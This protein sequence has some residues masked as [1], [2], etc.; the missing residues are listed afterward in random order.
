MSERSRN[1]KYQKMQERKR[2]LDKM[3]NA[4]AGGSRLDDADADAN[5]D[6]MFDEVTEE[7]YEEIVKSRLDADDFVVDDNGL[8]YADNGEELIA[9]AEQRRHHKKYALDD[10]DEDEDEDAGKKKKKKKHFDAQQD[11]ILNFAKPGVN[12]NNQ[13]SQMPSMQIDTSKDELNVDDLWGTGK[14]ITKKRKT[15]FK[16]NRD[17]AVANRISKTG[18]ARSHARLDASGLEYVGDIGA[19]DNMEGGGY[20]DNN[21]FSPMDTS[22]SDSAS[23]TVKKEEVL[24]VDVTKTKRKLKQSTGNQFHTASMDDALEP[25]LVGSAS[26]MAAGAFGGGEED[27]GSAT[28]DKSAIDP[29]WWLKKDDEGENYLNM[30]WIDATEIQGDIYLF[31]KIP[32][33]EPQEKLRYVSGMVQVRGNARN[34]F[35]LPKAIPGQTKEDGSAVRAALP[36]VYNEMKDILTPAIVPRMNGAL[37]AKP[38]KRNYAFEVS[39]V[40]RNETEYLKVKYHA[41]YPALRHEQCTSP[42]FKTIERIF[43][44]QS[45]PLELFLLKRKLMGPCW[46]RIK[47]PAALSQDRSFCKLEVGVENP[48]LILREKTSMPTPPLTCMSVSMK[49]VCNPTTHVNEIVALSAVVHTNM[50]CDGDSS[51]NANVLRRFTMVRQLGKSCGEGFPPTWPHDLPKSIDDMCRG[52]VE[53]LPNER[54]MLAKFLVK[55]QHE[56]PDILA[57]HN[58]FG[59][60]F[61]ILLKRAIFHKIPA[62][63]RLG[64]LRKTI[65]PR[66]IND[67]DVAAGR[68]LLDTYKTAKELIRETTYSLTALAE[69]QLKV[70]RQSVDPQD[71]PKYFYDSQNIICLASLCQTDAHLV[72]KLLM[73]LQIVPLTKQLTTC[74]GNLWSRTLRGARAE[75]IEYLLCHEFHKMKY[76]LP[77]R[78]QFEQKKKEPKKSNKSNEF[79]DNNDDNDDNNVGGMSR[80]RGKAAYAGGLVLEPKKGLYDTYILLLDFNSLYPSIIQEFN[81]C[82]TTIDWTKYMED[83]VQV[84]L[85]DEMGDGTN[86]EVELAVSSAK[87]LPDVPSN[88]AQ[89][90]VLPRVIKGLVDKR[91]QVKSLLKA[92]RDPTKKRQYDIRQK[93]LKLTANSMYGCLGF[94]FSRFY[95]R[96]IAALVTSKGREALQRT[97]DVATTNLGLDVIYGDT[98][99][100]MINT[101]STDLASVKEIGFKVMAE[102]NKLYKALVLDMD[103]IFKSML[104]L[105]KKKYAAVTITEVDGK[106]VLD[107]E[108]KGLDLVRRDWCPLSKDMGK[109]IVDEI[110]SGRPREEIVDSIHDKLEKLAKDVRDGNVDLERFIVTKGLNKL[111]QDYPDRKGQPHLLVATKMVEAGIPVNV[112]DHIPYVICTQGDEGATAPQ[113]ARHPDEVRRSNGE[114]TLDIEW[115][116]GHQILPPIAR[117]CEPI[118]GTGIQQ[119]TEK[120][121]LDTKKYAPHF[122]DDDVDTEGWGFVPKSRL[123]DAERF[124]DCEKLMIFC[125]TCSKDVEFMGCLQNSENIVSGL[126]CQECGSDY[127]GRGDGKFAAQN[128][129]S[130]ISNRVSLL[131]KKM[132]SKYYD[133]WLKC[134]DRTC[135]RRSRQQSIRGYA[136]TEDCHGRMVQEYNEEMVYTQLKYLESLFDFERV[137]KRREL[138]MKDVQGVIGPSHIEV[139]NTLQK[140]M[141]NT[142]QWSAYNWVRPSLWEAMFGSDGATKAHTVGTPTKYVASPADK[143]M[144]GRGLQTAM[145]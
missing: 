41:K 136:C 114:L 143:G 133:C 88:V 129:Y 117:L 141:S 94:S 128:G 104:L 90:G 123:D 115:Y 122:A 43:G 84:V 140:H 120:L 75:R 108:L 144:L 65:T 91:S 20:G 70:K 42:N 47:N 79:N 69:T 61:D 121:G 25:L 116:L 10:E 22:T 57:S 44:A 15:Q 68:L 107:K 82:F 92:E 18:A 53:I 39:S 28:L 87:A 118:D 81:L 45:T 74:S 48:K 13:A 126:K 62:W 98:D 93:A 63:N 12:N 137:V 139:F 138:N 145:A 33:Q 50:D 46:L 134:D 131:V 76:V 97:V 83:D 40:P 21:D 16:K 37:I 38:V 80:S 24:Q 60:E 102:V 101:N 52:R 64:R 14:D 23:V 110:L 66:S 54:T 127:F 135:G 4:R 103:G 119:I 49:T 106:E 130:H 67:R 142:I 30:F 125:K 19:P 35:V 56:D 55:I 32:V 78:K 95:A 1:Q 7:Q 112:G 71:V 5:D 51:E 36:E 3:R 17:I 132:V 105:K 72:L 58:L 85:N 2:T 27:Q 26:D 113:R 96:P 11:A 99:S 73:K 109:D 31:G 6:D 9:T 86:D 100:V 77:E 34:L 124:S 89:Q 29:S 111:P 8:G 59:F